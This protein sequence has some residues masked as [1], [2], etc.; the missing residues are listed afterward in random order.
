MKRMLVL[1]DGDCHFCHFW[2]RFLIARDS[3]GVIQFAPLS[4]FP[5]LPQTSIVAYQSG[6][7]F[8]RVRSEAVLAI[9]RSL[10]WPGWAVALVALIPL[11]FRD[12]L[13]EFVADRRYWVSWLMNFASKA[14]HCPRPSRQVLDRFLMKREE[15]LAKFPLLVDARR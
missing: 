7:A 5:E 6:D 13:Y 14:D 1:F 4:Q 3:R 11:Q 2:V 15:V 10:G 8:L 9:L 12:L